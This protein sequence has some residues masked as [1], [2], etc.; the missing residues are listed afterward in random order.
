MVRT[1]GY[2]GLLTANNH[3]IKDCKKI[4][5]ANSEYKRYYRDYFSL[6]SKNSYIYPYLHAECGENKYNIYRPVFA[7]FLGPILCLFIFLVAETC[8]KKR[9]GVIN[10]MWWK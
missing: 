3:L 10:K 5:N 8:L 7:K 4:V 1:Y 9:C 6:I 2:I